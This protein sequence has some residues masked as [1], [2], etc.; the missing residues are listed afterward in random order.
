LTTSNSCGSDTK[1]DSV[2]LDCLPPVSHFSYE[3]EEPYVKFHD[4]STIATTYYWDFGDFYYSSLKNPVHAYE[5][6]GKYYVCLTVTDSCGTSQYCD[7]VY[8]CPSPATKFVFVNDGHFVEFSDSSYQATKW[9]WDFD[10]GF[11]SDLENPVHYFNEF[12]TFFV[13]LTAT[14]NCRSQTYCDSVFVNTNGIDDFS[15]NAVTIYPN[16]SK[17]IIEM[18][19][20]G[21]HTN[22]GSFIISDMVGRVE[23]VI[24]VD[25]NEKN[26]RIDITML[27]D[28]MHLMTLFYPE[29]MVYRSK[30]IIAK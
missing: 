16:P 4:S 27:P 13:C 21:T 17:G 14:N 30:I 19:I 12:G 24:P 7:T 9:F 25:L 22:V 11:F 23:F 8:F 15:G 3:I 2:T 6:Y 20:P 18:T 5:D 26:K 1:C 29:N 28:G 10:D